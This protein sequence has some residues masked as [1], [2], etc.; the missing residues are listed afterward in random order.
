MGNDKAI[1]CLENES[2]MLFGKHKY[3]SKIYYSFYGVGK[4]YRVVKG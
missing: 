3:K 4:V 2:I 1:E